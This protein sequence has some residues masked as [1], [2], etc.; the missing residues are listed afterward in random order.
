MGPGGGGGG[1]IL[2]FASKQCHLNQVSQKSENKTGLLAK[3]VC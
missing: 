2:D 3:S 1:Q